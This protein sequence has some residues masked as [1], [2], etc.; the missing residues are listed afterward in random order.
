MNKSPGPRYLIYGAGAIG[1]VLGGFLHKIGGEVTF[2]GEKGFST[3][4]LSAKPKDIE[5]TLLHSPA[6]LSYI[7]SIIGIGDTAFISIPSSSG[8]RPRAMPTSWVT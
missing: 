8:P 2:A 6:I 3:T 1:S 7:R 4:L 5:I